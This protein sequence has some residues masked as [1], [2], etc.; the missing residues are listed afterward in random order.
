MR[1][2]VTGG[3]GFIGSHIVDGLVQ[4][5]N[6]VAVVDDLYLGS[7]ENLNPGARF[8]QVSITDFDRLETVFAQERPQIVNHHAAQTSVTRSMADPAFDAQVNIVGSLNVMQLCVKYGAD[9]LVFASTCAVYSEPVD[10]PMRESHPTAPQSAY[11]MAKLAVENYVLLYR[12]SYGLRSWV[13]RYGNVYGPRQR[14]GWENGVVA[15][16]ARQL[17]DGARPT[18]FG[19]GSKTRD[20]VFV[21]DVVRA[22][23]LATSADGN[24]DVLNVGRGIEVSDFEIFDLARNAVGSEVDPIYGD[25]RPG[26]ADRVSLDSYKARELLGWVPTVAPED[27]VRQTVEYYR[28]LGPARAR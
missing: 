25:R 8:H 20:Y 17:L 9:K 11:G 6:E 15:I 23:L 16:F 26:E 19:D 28:A 22:N 13:L 7:A 5:G 1:V 10:L 14:P 4:E 21:M 3:A 2:L 18:I 27:G 24:G 12:S